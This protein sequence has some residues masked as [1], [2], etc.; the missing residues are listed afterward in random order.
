MASYKCYKCGKKITDAE[1]KKRFAC[2]NCMS[3]IFVKPRTKSKK[4]KTD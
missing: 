2:P 1:L 3:K 4:I